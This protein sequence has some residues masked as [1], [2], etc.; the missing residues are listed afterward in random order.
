M[1]VSEQTLNSFPSRI[2]DL[3][4]RQKAGAQ[5]L[6]PTIAKLAEDYSPLEIVR[7]LT[8]TMSEELASRPKPK[9]Q[10]ALAQLRGTAAR[11]K[12]KLAEGGSLSAEESGERLGISKQA[13][14]KRFKKGQLLGW[15]NARQNAVRFPVW[16][17]DGD[18]VLNGLPEVLAVFAENTPWLDDWGKVA[19]FL[20]RKAS[21][22]ER[23]PLDLLRAGEKQ[24][25]L[26]AAE[27]MAE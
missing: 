5:N 8:A 12:L 17:F 3:K 13:V 9:S 22:K 25:V 15:R 23:N 4:G 2:A 20:N 21:M 27:A 19:F 1:T 11:E 7:M 14:L 6:Q 18:N 26:W 16:Q 10:L 24:A